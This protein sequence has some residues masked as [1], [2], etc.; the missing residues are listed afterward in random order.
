V[1]TVTKKSRSK[2]TT[3]SENKKKEKD[4]ESLNFL[5]IQHLSKSFPAALKQAY[6]KLRPLS[7]LVGFPR[8]LPSFLCSL[9]VFPTTR[10]FRHTFPS[11]QRYVWFQHKTFSI[12]SVAQTRNERK[13]GKRMLNSA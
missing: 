4:D 10:A 11:A 9:N 2:C 8:H 13:A 1:L 5:L 12:H 3:T 7:C 6:R